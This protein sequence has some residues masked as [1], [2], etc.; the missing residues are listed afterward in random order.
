MLVKQ[1]CS[2]GSKREIL[3]KKKSSVVARI[4]TVENSSIILKLWARR[5]CGA[6]FREVT[7]SGAL[8]KELKALHRL[9]RAGCDVPEVLGFSLI[10]M[11][12]IE[13]THA[14]VLEDITPSKNATIYLNNLVRSGDYKKVAA[15]EESLIQMTIQMVELGVV[16][17]DH[18]LVNIVVDGAG[19]PF[20]LDF[21]MATLLGV[22][23]FLARQYGKMIGRLVASIVY[24]VQPNVELAERF[25]DRL[26]TALQPSTR[27][28]R[29][30]KAHIDSELEKQRLEKGIDVQIRIP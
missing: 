29:I 25:F 2:G 10:N 28:I 26:V 18:S 24:A 9:H 27:V 16:D 11:S 12:D 1:F 20:R 4:A 22:N 7:K 8:Y 17:A 23:Y 19:V 6:W 14:I 30:A 5:G 15:F 3:R 13:Y 21:E